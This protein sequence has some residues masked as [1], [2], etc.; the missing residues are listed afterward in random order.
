MITQNFYVIQTCWIMN[1]LWDCF[2]PENAWLP[3]AMLCLDKNPSSPRMG[4]SWVQKLLRGLLGD[5]LFSGQQHL[6]HR[7]NFA[8]FFLL[9]LYYYIRW[10]AELHSTSD[11]QDTAFTV[12]DHPRS[13]HVRLIK[14]IRFTQTA[15]SSELLHCGTNSRDNAFLTTTFLASLS[16]GSIDIYSTWPH[17]TLLLPSPLKISISNSSALSGSWALYWV[18]DQ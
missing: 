11:S 17:N 14:K 2:D 16:P 7:R 6:S 15:S 5:E 18:N 8:C 9:Y 10:T 12:I 4:Y 3:L 1:A 13:F